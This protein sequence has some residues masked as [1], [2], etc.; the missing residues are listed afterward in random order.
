MLRIIYL[1]IF[2]ILF[3]FSLLAQWE[4][5]LLINN[6]DR[7]GFIFQGFRYK[8]EDAK[9]K[10]GNALKDWL[11][12]GYYFYFPS[13]NKSFELG[14]GIWDKTDHSLNSEIK[15]VTIGLTYYN[16]IQNN[17]K[18][19]YGADLGVYKLE[20]EKMDNI[21]NKNSYSESSIGIEF[22]IG[23][24]YLLSEDFWLRGEIRY[25]GCTIDDIFPT[26]PRDSD[27]SDLNFS[28]SGMAF[29]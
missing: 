17:F 29:F 7:N 4:D 28:I 21:G 16:N 18:F 12:R 26:S 24:A 3:N 13:N 25:I 27:I 2:I 15:S 11:I 19:L 14:F 5:Y 6:E 8:P 23:L 22:K 1:F 10:N 20:T 9:D